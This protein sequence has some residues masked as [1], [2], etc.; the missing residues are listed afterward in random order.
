[1]FIPVASPVLNGNEKSYVMDC[2]NP[3]GF[4]LLVN[5][6]KNLKN[7][8]LIFVALNTLYH[9]VMELLRC[10]FHC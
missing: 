10:T 4:H 1:M 8:L 5:T 9:V 3:L 2:L 6:Y 7:L